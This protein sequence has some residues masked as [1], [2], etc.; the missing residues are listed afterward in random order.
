MHPSPSHRSP[1]EQRLAWLAFRF[2][3]TRCEE[4]RKA[5]AA[6]YA[7]TVDRLISSG[8]WDR[9]PGPEEQLPDAWMPRAFFEYLAAGEANP[10]HPPGD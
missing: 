1:D 4:E 6:D 9:M 5:I 10:P 7:K 8:C 2:R 3:G